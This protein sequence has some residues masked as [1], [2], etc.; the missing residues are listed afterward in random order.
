MVTLLDA[1]VI[2]RQE[3]RANSVIMLSLV[4]VADNAYILLEEACYLVKHVE[5]HNR[6]EL[7]DP[8]SVRQIGAYHRHE[9]ERDTFIFVN[10]SKKL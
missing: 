2:R 9:K 7:S 6:P 10:A 3:G 8:C 5:E 4:L 1:I